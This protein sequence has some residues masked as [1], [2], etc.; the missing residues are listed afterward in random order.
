VHTGITR[1][2]DSLA[3][4]LAAVSRAGL[5]DIPTELAARIVRRVIDSEALG[6]R[7]DV[8]AFNSAQ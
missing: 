8:A 2:P 7:V 3:I 4:T 6:P 1:E 5:C